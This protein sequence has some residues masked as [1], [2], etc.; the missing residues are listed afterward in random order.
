MVPTAKQELIFILDEFM[1][2]V[3]RF[4][5][6]FDNGDLRSNY[7]AAKIVIDYLISKCENDADVALPTDAH[8]KATIEIAR[9]HEPI[10]E[11]IKARSTPGKPPKIR[12]SSPHHAASTFALRT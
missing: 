11:A 6:I 10:H 5:D 7:D 3:F 8:I 12:A 4:D 2:W 1:E 9:L